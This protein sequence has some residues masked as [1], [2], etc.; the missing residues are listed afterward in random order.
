[1]RQQNN[2]YIAD[3]CSY[4]PDRLIAFGVLNPNPGI[5]GGNKRHAAELIIEEAERC[6]HQQ[7]IRGISVFAQ[8]RLAAIS[9]NRTR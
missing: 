3:F 2:D 8:P 7:G 5:A 6:Y 1:M 9:V 4:A